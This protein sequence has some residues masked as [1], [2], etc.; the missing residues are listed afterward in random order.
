MADDTN[1]MLDIKTLLQVKLS[2]P[3]LEFALKLERNS[4][5]SDLK[6]TPRCHHQSEYYCMNLDTSGIKANHILQNIVTIKCNLQ[7]EHQFC[8][9]SFIFTFRM[10]LVNF[11]NE[12]I[13]IKSLD[14]NLLA[15]NNAS[16]IKSKLGKSQE[17]VQFIPDYF[18]K[19]YI[20][21]EN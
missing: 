14:S 13:S 20:E 12:N 3:N 8:V 9:L 5:T 19:V 17:A 10:S 2:V 7:S 21:T 11:C 6:M 18:R 1:W 15:V 4:N 16:L